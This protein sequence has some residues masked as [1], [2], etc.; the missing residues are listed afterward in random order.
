[1]SDEEITQYN[2]CSEDWRHYDRAIWQ[3]PTVTI[4]IASGILA[5]A[6]RYVNE[7][8]PRAVIL[9]LGGLLL[10]SIT[11]ALVKHRVF[12]EQRTGF[13]L[14]IEKDW[15][16]SGRVTRTIKRKTDEIQQLPW[17]KKRKGFY[18]LR[19]AMI[20]ATAWLFGLSIYN[21]YLFFS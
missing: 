2:Q 11:V 19:N 8:L 18:W 10:L 17:H 13:L 7:F 4:T 6:Y 15:V 5:V 12:Q 21:F 9:F 16:A 20:I 14:D 1:M 3:M